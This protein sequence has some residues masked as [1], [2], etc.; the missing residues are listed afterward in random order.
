MILSKIQ[1]Q[2]NMS[3]INTLIDILNFSRD[4]ILFIYLPRDQSVHIVILFY[5]IIVFIREQ[6]KMESDFCSEW[7]FNLT[8]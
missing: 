8:Q 3:E 7:G 1:D 6:C 5:L 2:E 4:N